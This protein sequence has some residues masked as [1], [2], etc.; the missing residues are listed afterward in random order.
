MINFIS[1]VS[2]WPP[3]FMSFRMKQPIM[4]KQCTAGIGNNK[5]QKKYF[6]LGLKG[7]SRT[8]TYRIYM[9]FMIKMRIRCLKID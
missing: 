7:L 8:C 9:L 2:K 4:K 5:G 6:F 3:K 1:D